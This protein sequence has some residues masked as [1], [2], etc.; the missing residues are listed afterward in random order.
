[1]EEKPAVQAFNEAEQE[2]KQKRIKKVM[3]DA[4]KKLE[5]EGVKYFIG[6]VDRQPTHTD[7]GKVYTQLDATGEDFIHIL[8]V[9]LP[10]R[11]DAINLGIWVGQILNSRNPQK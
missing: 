2:A 3:D 10:T 6:V 5:K 7:G 1:M 4:A 9:A 8:D 11:Q